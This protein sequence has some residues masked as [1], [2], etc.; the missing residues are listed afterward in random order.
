MLKSRFG[1]ACTWWP[2]HASATLSITI[3]YWHDVP[4]VHWFLSSPIRYSNVYTKNEQMKQGHTNRECLLIA[5]GRLRCKRARNRSAMYIVFLKVEC[6]HT[7]CCHVRE[8]TL[9]VQNYCRP[10]PL[11]SWMPLW[12]QKAPCSYDLL[13][14]T[15]LLYCHAPEMVR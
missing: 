1:I 15:R 4:L 11:R 7:H 8:Q 3:L 2:T 10:G 6:K 9:N 13:F 12:L 5:D 14:N